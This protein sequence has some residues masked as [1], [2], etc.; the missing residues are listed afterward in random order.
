MD[1]Q[2][3]HFV[4]RDPNTKERTAAFLIEL[5]ARANVDALQKSLTRE[6]KTEK[7]ERR[8]AT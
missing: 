3:H 2:K 1:R 6:E 8:N 4:I 7:A 5:C